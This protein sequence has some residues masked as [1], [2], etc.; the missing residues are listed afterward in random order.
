MGKFS[1]LLVL[2]T[3]KCS[4]APNANKAKARL[5]ATRRELAEFGFNRRPAKVFGPF[6]RALC[7]REGSPQLSVVRWGASGVIKPNMVV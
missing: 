4:K 6:A 2:P 3:K 5:A 1:G 7:V